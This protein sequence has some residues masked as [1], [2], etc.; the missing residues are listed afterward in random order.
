PAHENATSEPMNQKA[1]NSG[2]SATADVVGR[3]ARAGAAAAITPSC[4]SPLGASAAGA[5]ACAPFASS[6]S[7]S[8]TAIDDAGPSLAP[9]ASPTAFG[10]RSHT[11]TC[12]R[13]KRKIA[14]P[15]DP[16]KPS[17]S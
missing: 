3:G 5:S 13:V 16:K 10:G 2:K 7:A 9:G 8:A 14:A 11:P 17:G 12:G 15:I 1:R 4:Q 6:A